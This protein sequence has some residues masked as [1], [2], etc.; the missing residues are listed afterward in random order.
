M[1]IRGILI[2][3]IIFMAV[4]MGM[5][6]NIMRGS[7][8]VENNPPAQLVTE[9]TALDVRTKV[10]AE[11]TLVRTIELAGQTE[12]NRRETVLAQSGGTLA[13]VRADKGDIVAAGDVI[14]VITAAA[15]DD[16]LRQAEAALEA[17]RVELEATTKLVEEGFAARNSLVTVQS[18]YETAAAGLEQ[19]R[20]QIS[21]LDVKSTLSG[22]VENRIAQIGGFVGSGD[23]VMAITSLDPMIVSADAGERQ[24]AEFAIGQAATVELATGQV[25]EAKI[26]Y[27]S[28]FADAATRT[29][30]IE[31]EAPNA[32][33]KLFEGVSATMQVDKPT[34]GLHYVPTGLLQRALSGRQ[35][36]YSVV[37]GNTVAFTPVKVISAD[38]KGSWVEGLNGDVTLI[39]VGQASVKAGQMV[40]PVD[41]SVVEQMTAEER[42]SD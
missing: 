27:I 35:G 25:V 18:A 28:P 33:Y 16:S 24:V 13:E 21:D 17:A 37:E 30:E 4:A 20:E 40:N 26:S 2:A 42:I 7:T 19:A 6:M 23:P 5:V 29:F 41:E 38:D 31:A 22:I 8:P 9:D 36:L 39:T 10:F 32:D 11:E 14:A 34:T 3:L 12:A 1:A 15:R